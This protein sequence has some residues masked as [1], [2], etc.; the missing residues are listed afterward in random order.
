MQPGTLGPCSPRLIVGVRRLGTEERRVLSSARRSCSCRA[1][2]V[3]AEEA[4]AAAR[5]EAAVSA[6]VEGRRLRRKGEEL[7]DEAGADPDGPEGRDG[8]PE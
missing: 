4:C 1:E 7:D 5:E 6:T 3:A 2:S 8:E